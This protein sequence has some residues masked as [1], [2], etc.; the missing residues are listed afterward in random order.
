MTPQ[1]SAKR[2]TSAAQAA[3]D[4]YRQTVLRA[5]QGRTERFYPGTLVPVPKNTLKRIPLRAARAT[6]PA[7][8]V[9]LPPHRRANR[10]RRH[11]TAP[12]TL[13]RAPASAPTASGTRP[14]QRRASSA[15]RPA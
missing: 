9:P 12:T 10:A 14:A 11:R 7:C 1:A 15:T 5:Q 6:T 2:A 4:R 13:Q 3:Q 8:S